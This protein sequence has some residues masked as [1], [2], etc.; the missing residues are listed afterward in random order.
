M[1]LGAVNVQRISHAQIAMSSFACNAW[2]GSCS[3]V[4]SKTFATHLSAYP[5]L[6]S[7]VLVER[8]CRKTVHLAL[9]ALN[10][11]TLGSDPKADLH[12]CL[13]AGV[14]RLLWCFV[15]ATCKAAH[16]LSKVK[17]LLVFVAYDA[18]VFAI[19]AVS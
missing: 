15:G 16:T 8:T 13:Q 14:V 1:G 2:L 6:K 11:R 9:A 4:S 10:V 18:L 5:N 12:A 3:K 7:Q 17:E 19:S